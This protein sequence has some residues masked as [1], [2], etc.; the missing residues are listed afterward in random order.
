[1]G[2]FRVYFLRAGMQKQFT[3]L[4]Q[5]GTL[6]KVLGTK[7]HLLHGMGNKNCG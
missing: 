3:G 4:V 1:M 6:E 5:T 7:R 2:K